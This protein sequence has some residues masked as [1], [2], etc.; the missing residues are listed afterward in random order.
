MADTEAKII[1]QVEFYF[2]DSNLPND[3]FLQK[4]QSENDGWV[5]VKTLLTFKRLNAICN[6]EAKIVEALKL[7]ESG[8]LEISEDGSKLKRTK[9]LETDLAKQAAASIYC[10]GFAEDDTLENIEAFFEENAPGK[11]VNAIR[12]RR[13]KATKKFKT[14][15]FVEFASAEEAKEVTEMKLK[16]KDTPLLV[17][18]KN[19][20]LERKKT[21][22][23]AAKSE[24][25]KNGNSKEEELDVSDRVK[26]VFIKFEAVN[27]GTSREDLKESFSK[28]GEV[29][30]VDFQRGDS[31][32]YIRFAA[33]SD[34]TK[35][36]EAHKTEK[37]KVCDG[38]IT[39]TALDD[40]EDLE[41]WKKIARMKI[42]RK[43]RSKSKG[44]KRMGG[45]DN[46]ASKK[47]KAF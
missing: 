33:P 24:K 8:L 18:M 26:G 34:V 12:M 46:R 23:A 13:D 17:E 42:E 39:L 7:S 40:D 14:S 44:Y 1:R 20:Y 9:V 47:S 43:N 36:L 2:G 5:P 32:G 29:S 11:T 6:E 41:Q 30:W 38:D 15:V 4:V 25:K 37:I 21:E 35:V 27:D 22:R 19:D 31:E 45:R 10:K 28:H 16:Y 3:K